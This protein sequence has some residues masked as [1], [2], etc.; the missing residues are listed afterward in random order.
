[1]TI[2]QAVRERILYYCAQKH[3]TVNGLSTRCGITQSTLQNIVSGR[4][5]SVTL[6]TIKKICDGLDISVVEFF[7]CEL[8]E[9]LEQ[10]LQ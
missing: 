7:S 6:S 9:T 8:F 10:E 3:L 5:H 1:M 2:K 4:N